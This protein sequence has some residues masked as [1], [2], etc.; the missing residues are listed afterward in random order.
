MLGV[1][2][3]HGLAIALMVTAFGHISGGHFNP[4]ITLGFVVTRRI[5]SA[6]CGRLLVHAVRG[7]LSLPSLLWWIFPGGPVGPS[8]LGRADA[9]HPA[10]G[11]EA[12]LVLEAIMT[13]FLVIAVFS[14]LP[15]TSA[16]RSRRWP[17]SASAS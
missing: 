9:L 4:A 15:S 11:N 13:G 6:A 12:G 7:R 14:R 10:I 1:A 2:L 16:E 5:E 17:A 3:A 8:R